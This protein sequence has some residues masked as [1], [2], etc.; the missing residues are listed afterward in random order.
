[1]GVST[2]TPAFP[3]MQD[4]LGISSEQIGLV[5]TAFTLP[6]IA[7]TPLFG[8]LA[9][10]YGRKTIL[11]PSLF[12]FGIAGFACA[13]VREFELLLI[14]RF[15]QG[16]GGASLGSLNV[17]LIGDLY[18]TEKRSTAMGYNSSVLSV[19]TASYPA[20]GGGLAVLGW[21]YPFYL[22]IVGL[23][24]GLLVLWVLDNPDVH[25]DTDMK[26]YILNVWE[27]LKSKAVAG[28][29][30]TNFLTFI[31][32]FGT[33]L[34]F[35]PVL[36]DE[37]FGQSAF[38][39]G[40]FLSLASLTTAVTA[41]QLGRL[42]QRFPQ[43]HL[44]AFSAVLYTIAFT[45]LA[46]LSTLTW[47]WLPTIL[48]G[49]AQGINIPTVMNLL[50]HQSPMEYRAAFLSVN[51]MIMRSGQT[52]GPVLLG[53]VYRYYSLTGVFITGGILACIMLVVVWQLIVS[54]I[55]G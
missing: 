47:L 40:L 44:I 48:F 7:L 25:Q 54:T 27:T 3:R 37:R 38:V 16:I 21:Y 49:V 8:V 28:L 23:P 13:F 20:I 42:S 11:V 43:S 30:L 52:L 2:I 4:A 29:F 26:S 53:L 50:T 41:S 36:M 55:R 39:I 12:L 5:I 34:T 32:L 46:Y 15:L 31:L 24:V 35:F 19:G 6:G 45:M 10:R 51:W 14:M 22:N 17:T 18:P 9:D 1:M 33:V